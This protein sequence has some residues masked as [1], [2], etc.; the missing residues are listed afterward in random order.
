[1]QLNFKK[2]YKTNAAYD[3]FIFYEQKKNKENVVLS[4]KNR[5]SIVSSSDD[6]YDITRIVFYLFSDMS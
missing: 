4:F 6:T 1:M 2:E 5:T 3:T